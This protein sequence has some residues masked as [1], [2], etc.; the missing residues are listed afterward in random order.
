MDENYWSKAMVKND[1][2]S[3]GEQLVGKI[4]TDSSTINLGQTLMKKCLL[5]YRQEINESIEQE[6]KEELKS[7]YKDHLLLKSNLDQQIQE[8]EQPVYM[9][10]QGIESGK[11]RWQT[12]SNQPEGSLEFMRELLPANFTNVLLIKQVKP[13]SQLLGQ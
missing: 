11:P 10:L 9:S 13:L 1:E 7:N 12:Y 3:I 5:H 6:L 4:S 2:T 8:F